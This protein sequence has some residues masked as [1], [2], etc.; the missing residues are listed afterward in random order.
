MLRFREVIRRGADRLANFLTTGTAWHEQH[1]SAVCLIPTQ[2]ST[3][4]SGKISRSRDWYSTA[5]IQI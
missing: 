4:P 5:V 1:V 3:L 2:T